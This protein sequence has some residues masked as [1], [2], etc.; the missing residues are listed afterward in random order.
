MLLAFFRTVILKFS[1]FQKKKKCIK[2]GEVL[3]RLRAELGC[4]GSADKRAYS[5]VEGGVVHLSLC[6]EVV[7][8]SLEPE[9]SCELERHFGPL[10]S[11]RTP[12]ILIVPVRL[13]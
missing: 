2:V 4:V 8:Y 6:R 1:V 9:L 12:S 11:K 3:G 10:M 13:R 5:R 7:K